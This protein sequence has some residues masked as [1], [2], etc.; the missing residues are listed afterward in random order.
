MQL[1]KYR[2]KGT[3]V[4][5]KLGDRCDYHHGYM[6]PSTGYLRWFALTPM[7]DGFALRFPAPP[8]AE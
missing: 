3:L 8:G 2:R 6:V 1:L 7:G 5:Y 4:L